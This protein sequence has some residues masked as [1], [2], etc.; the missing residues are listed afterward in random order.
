VCELIAG[1]TDVPVT[2]ETIENILDVKMA[3]E[4]IT[5]GKLKVTENDV[6]Y[7]GELQNGTPA[8]RSLVGTP[9]F[10]YLMD[11][12]HTGRDIMPVVRCCEKLMENTSNNSVEQLLGF[13]D[14]KGLPLC[15]DGDFLAYKAVTQDFLDKWSRKFDN[16][17]GSIVEVPR[18]AVC[19]DANRACASGLHAGSLK[20]AKGYG[21]GEDQMIVIKINPR[22]A[23]AVP[24]IE[25]T[26]KLRCCRY[27]VVAHLGRTQESQLLPGILYDIHGN[28]IHEQFKDDWKKIFE[29]D[30]PPYTQDDYDY[31]YDDY[32]DDYHDD[33]D[34]YCLDCGAMLDA[35]GYCSCEEL[36][37]DYDYDDYDDD[38]DYDDYND[39]DLYE[40][41]E[42]QD[43]FEPE[44]S[45]RGFFA[46]FLSSFRGRK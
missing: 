34:N 31:D 14:Q 35:Y 11:I 16:S 10:N 6:I 38:Y 27:E 26:D 25:S 33:D 28:Q 37:D 41:E 2:K 20:Y 23:V 24:K 29:N 15:E 42:T 36:D 9:I 13:L 18:N 4:E 44:Q 1:V 12:L 45:H 46:S 19:D 5:S 8:S 43:E 39:C 7:E 17:V 3:I 22:D 40:N 30:Y 21:N 32:Y